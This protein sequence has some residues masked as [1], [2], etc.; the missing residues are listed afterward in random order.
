MR[1][2]RGQCPACGWRGAIKK[3][4]RPFKHDRADTFEAARVS[5][6]CDGKKPGESA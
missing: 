4:G 5:V 6:A 2:E 3:N 1:A